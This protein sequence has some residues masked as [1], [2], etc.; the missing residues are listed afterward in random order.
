MTRYQFI[1]NSSD[2]FVCA[3]LASVTVASRQTLNGLVL[4]PLTP[5]GPFESDANIIFSLF[6]FVASFSAQ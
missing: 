2:S 4:V 1:F 6:F 3:S 5:V